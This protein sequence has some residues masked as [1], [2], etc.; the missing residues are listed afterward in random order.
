MFRNRLHATVSM[1]ALSAAMLAA[2]PASAQEVETV[3]VTGF[4][5]SMI[6]SEAI[7]K[8]S[9]NLVEAISALDI[10]KLPDTSIADSLARLPGL[11]AQR[12]DG[13]SQVIAIRGLSPDFAGTTFNGRDQVSTG[14]NR[15]VEFDQYPAEILTGVVVYKSSDPVI[16]GAGLSG[17]VDLKSARPLDYDGR[18][19]ALGARGEYSTL[20]NLT[21]EVSP[22]GQRYNVTYIDQFLNKKLGVAIGFAHLDSPFQEEHYKAWWWANTDLWGTPQAGKP[23]D[24]TALEGAELWARSKDQVR[25]SMIATVELQANDVWHSTLDLY[26]SNFNQK[27][28]MHGIMWTADPW[29]AYGAN[30]AI[31]I[32]NAGTTDYLGNKLVTSG[33]W[34]YVRP[35]VRND[36][37]TRVDVLHSVG[38][39]NEF[40]FGKLTAFAD[41]S[42]SDAKRNESQMELYAG[43][44]A[45]SNVAFDVPTR[46]MFPSLKPSVSFADPANV[47]LFDA[48]N[49]GHDGRIGIPH[50]KD[51]IEAARLD[52]KYDF[53]GL[54]DNVEL[55]IN[56]QTRKKSRSYVVYFATQKTPLSQVSSDLLYSPVSLDF[57]GFGP[58]LSFNPAAVAAKYYNTVLNLSDGDVRKDFWVKEK[59]ATTYAKINFK[60]E[61]GGVELKGNVGAQLIHTDQTSSAF[62]LSGYVQG[63]TLPTASNLAGKSYWDFLPAINVMADFGGGS[64]LRAVVAKTMARPRMDEMRAA[65][66]ASVDLLT[67]LWSGSGGNPKLAPWRADAIDISFE[68]YISDSSYFAIAGFYKNLTSYVYQQDVPHFDFTGYIDPAGNTSKASSPYGD[69]YT[70]ANGKGGYVR[71]MEVSAQLDGNLLTDVLDG[72]GATASFSWTDT[73]IKPDGPGTALNATLPGLSKAVGDLTLYYEKNGFSFRVAEKYR[74]DFR[75]EIT[76]LFADRVFT[77]ILAETQTDLQIGYDFQTGSLEGLSLQFQVNNLFNSAYRTVQDPSTGSPSRYPL[78]YNLYGRQLLMGVNYKL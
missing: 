66:S 49:W 13:R 14:D 72:F 24:A 1:A 43:R 60:T 7:K 52:A 45:V 9:V 33:T 22:F 40:N 57:A 74:S 31:G 53:G 12:V 55:G 59:V 23:S 68:H 36:Y 29:T 61:V 48:Q 42:F 44:T 16:I 30:P 54:I 32:Q 15:G 17:T 5:Q 27:E 3:T 63:S 35:V 46:P 41:V 25:D 47:V 56:Y 6:S 10:G 64:I 20:G 8:D 65:A 73:S 4:R 34:Q 38:W 76:G 75:G 70:T 28:Y 67:H 2:I 11:A 39:K 50:Q 71:G 62:N 21:P 18:Q 51:V 19:I 77:R 69:Y 26:Y 58:I 78:E 37:N